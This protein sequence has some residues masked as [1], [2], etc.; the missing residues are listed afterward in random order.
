MNKIIDMETAVKTTWNLD[1]AHSEIGFKVKHMMISTVTGHFED[2]NATVT[3][4]SADFKNADFDF[5]ASVGSINTKN[6]DRDNHLKSN[7]FFN[8][9]AHPEITFKSTSF[10]GEKMVGDLTLRDV[11]KSIELEVDFNG[12]AVDPYGQTK[13]GFEMTGKINRKDFGLA[14]SAV[15]EA[16]S[17]V[18]A[19][20]VKLVIDLQFIQE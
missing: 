5:V 2:F 17:V 6:A 18:V 7:D 11:T 8:A 9:E 12:I 4:D 10:D 15:T 20:Q 19:E 1:S 3:T 16:G 13:A 14:W